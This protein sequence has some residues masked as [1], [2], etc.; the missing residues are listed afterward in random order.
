[1]LKS[2][3][4]IRI[5]ELEGQLAAAQRELEARS[6]TIAVLTERVLERQRN[7]SQAF[8]HLEQ[9]AALQEVVE[10]KTAELFEQ[11][12]RLAEA[13]A[14]LKRTQA[15]LLQASRQEVIG[16]L[17]AG[18]AH[19]MNTPLQYVGCNLAFL[20]EAFTSVLAVV[21]TFQSIHE[22]YP[23]H[24]IPP[25][26]FSPLVEALLLA[27]VNSFADEVQAAL[28]E[29]SEG[30]SR[31]SNIVSAMRKFANP[32]QGPK[33][34]VNLGEMIDAT[35]ILATAEWREVAE[36]VTEFAP[37][38]PPVPGRPDELSQVTLNLIVNAA[39]T[40]QEHPRAMLGRITIQAACS[41]SM[42]EIRVSD[43]GGGIPEELRERIFEPFFTTKAVGKGS[44]QGLALARSIIVDAHGGQLFYESQL[45]C[46]TTFVIRLPLQ[47]P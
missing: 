36:V 26:G 19:E 22:A 47:E 44:G 4:A 31:V 8:A 37:D 34:M 42:A 11:N 10:R 40:I 43:T 46:G 24:A 5:A 15:Q 29:T 32:G 21:R 13:H 1:M 9:N 33:Q 17:A 20:T 39:H 28:G 14:D 27:D 18:I 41:D 7:Q 3:E 38:L 45:G 12:Q 6:K 16:Q 2:D 25:E 35:V 23:D 30:L